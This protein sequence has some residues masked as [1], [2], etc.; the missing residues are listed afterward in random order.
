MSEFSLLFFE[1]HGKVLASL[2]SLRLDAKEDNPTT[3]WAVSVIE[4]LLASARSDERCN[5][6]FHN[7]LAKRLLQGPLVYEPSD[8]A[9]I[10][11]SFFGEDI[12]Q[13]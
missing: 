1:N 4:E 7:I 10:A 13:V 12:K 6:V 11:Y 2:E 9:S 5:K 3:A 8:E